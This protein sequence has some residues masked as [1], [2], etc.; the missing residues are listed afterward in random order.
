MHELGTELGRFI[1]GLIDDAQL[2][3]AFDAYLARHP[4]QRAEVAAWLKDSVQSGRLSATI[5]LSLSDLFEP[6][7]ASPPDDSSETRLTSIHT[8]RRRATLP[9]GQPSVA[10]TAA[11]PQ[12]SPQL[13]IPQGPTERQVRP[14]E[15]GTGLRPGMVIRERF[16]LME[17]LGSG[18]MGKVFKARDLRREEAMD[19]HPFIALKVLN[20]EMGAHPDS[21]MALQRE[22]RRAG[23]LAHPNVVT[24]YDFDR[25]GDRIFMTMEY[26]EGRPLDSF[27]SEE[28]A[29]GLPFVDA[30]PIIAAIGGA[31][32]FGH[33]KR[34]VHSDLKPANIFVC[35]DGTVKVLDFGIARLI[36][37]AGAEGDET[38]FDPSQRLGGLTPAYA[39]LEMWS[40]E[41]PDPRDD[42]YAFA[43]VCYEL[44]TGEH[45]FGRA[46]AR[47]VRD[48]SLVAPRIESLKRGQWDSIRKGLALHRE[49]RTATVR[50][51]LAGL[52]SRS[53]W[54]RHGRAL[55]IA[56]AVLALSAVIVGSQFFR[57]A[58]E[59]DTMEVLRCAQIIKP[60][61]G[62][63]NNTVIELT[64]QRQQ[65]LQDNILLAD[66]Y[67]ADVKDDTPVDALKAMLS[68][69]PNSVND[70][71]NGVLAADP[72][73]PQALKLKRQ[74]AEIYGKRAQESLRQQ[75]TKEALDLV[76]HGRGVLPSSQELF[77]LEQAVCRA[78]A[79]ASRNSGG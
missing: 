77:R 39:S 45:P 65:E 73:Q 32:E 74:V 29:H 33:R 76:R 44:L 53:V 3:A 23:T 58:V 43:C 25:D 8:P 21:F 37:P 66:D 57:A 30:W 49:Q 71:L 26:L 63:A 72:K 18:G 28:Y 5:W 50:E 31:L 9:P 24:V 70:I 6:P 79:L 41:A 14:S 40:Q 11:A 68:D 47:E 46:S 19:R 67:L 20:A 1:G 60:V 36:R 52:E 42:I 13:E 22:A 38:I 54:Q 69:G 35:D 4:E 55:G 48:K 59:S 64:P 7:A 17:E 62:S 61:A 34:I 78:D 75:R 12:V 51:F 2:H 27:L 10:P 15:Q 16:V 56:A